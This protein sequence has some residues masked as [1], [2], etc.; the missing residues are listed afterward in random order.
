MRKISVIM[1]SFLGEY[2]GAAVNREGKFVRALLSFTSQSYETKELIIIS[3]GCKK[4][5]DVT[6]RFIRDGIKLLSIEKQEKFSG[7]VRN[8]GLDVATGD[9]ICYLDTDDYF[10]D[11]N[12]LQSI[13]DNFKGQLCYMNDYILTPS[14]NIS[15]R[16]V[17]PNYG[18]IGTSAIAH[19]KTDVRWKDGYGHDF[20]FF[21]ELA[22]KY[23]PVKINAGSYFVCHIPGKLDV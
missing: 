2:E 6:N 14:Y 3:D 20:I 16:N 21:S 19:T 7:A 10:G 5:I 15:T 22:A 18:S 11:E 8:K 1:P 9:I 13:A 4:T 12:H 23:K 17:T